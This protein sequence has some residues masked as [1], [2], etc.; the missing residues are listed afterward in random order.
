V[1]TA[2]RTAVKQARAAIGSGDLG[3]AKAS[4]AAASRALARAATKG[5]VHD[6]TASRSVSRIESALHRLTK[7]AQ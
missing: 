2:V 1:L 7:S 4:V 3:A 5:V 6:R